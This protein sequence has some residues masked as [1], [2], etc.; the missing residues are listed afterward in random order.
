MARFYFDLSDE[1]SLD[2]DETGGEYNDLKDAEREAVRTVA[3]LGLEALRDR[4]EERFILTIRDG[5]GPAI[6]IVA[7][8]RSRPL[9]EASQ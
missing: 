2:L 4:A 6:E 1:Q 3:S 5:S 7:I 8:F 9:R